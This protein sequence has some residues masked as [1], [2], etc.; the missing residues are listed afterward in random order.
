MRCYLFRLLLILITKKGN[1]QVSFDIKKC[2]VVKSAHETVD[3][4]ETAAGTIV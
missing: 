2:I 1:V 4:T 3:A